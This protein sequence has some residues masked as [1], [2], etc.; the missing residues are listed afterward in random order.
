MAFGKPKKV[1]MKRAQ[2]TK[3]AVPEVIPSAVLSNAI[4]KGSPPPPAPIQ[5]KPRQP[6]SPG[7]AIRKMAKGVLDG[8]LKLLRL[9]LGALHR[10]GTHGQIGLR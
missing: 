10:T 6:L 9:G 8:E 1:G 5:S 2:K 4:P 3:V 7:V